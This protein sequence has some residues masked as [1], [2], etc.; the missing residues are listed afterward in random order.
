ML[1]L[2][3]IASTASAIDYRTVELGDGR[4]FVAEVNAEHEDGL[5]LTVPPG[6]IEIKHAQV[7]DMAPADPESYMTQP[8]W[9]VYVANGPDR[10]K[11]Q[12]AYGEMPGVTVVDGSPDTMQGIDPEHLKA[13][14]ACGSDLFCLTTELAEAPW[15]WIV[16]AEKRSGKTIGLKGRLNTEHISFIGAYKKRSS[17]EMSKAIA[18]AIGVEPL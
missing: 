5:E 11:L 6:R 3:L 14:E 1:T 15:M 10:R 16:T 18:N 8:D 13:A 17:S 9:R 12:A 7:A 2:L 4:A